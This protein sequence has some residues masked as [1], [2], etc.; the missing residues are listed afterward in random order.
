MAF[1]KVEEFLITLGGDD[2][3]VFTRLSIE[4]EM[5]DPAETPKLEING[6]HS[7]LDIG[8]D[9]ERYA[10]ILN[11]FHTVE[12]AL[13]LN[14]VQR[15]HYDDITQE[16]LPDNEEEKRKLTV[17]NVK[18]TKREPEEPLRRVRRS[19]IDGDLTRIWRI[20]IPLAFFREGRNE[21]LARRY[22]NA[23]QD[24]YYVL[25]GLFGEGKTKDVEGAMKASNDLRLC[26][27]SVLKVIRG[28]PDFESR[29][30]PLF[31][32]L[33]LNIDVD[34]LVDFIVKYRHRLHHFWVEKREW[35]GHP[36]NHDE[37]RD[38]ALV[39]MLLSMTILEIEESKAYGLWR[40]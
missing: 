28:N 24:F 25:E 13:T 38:P 39:L 18:F 6:D 26:S 3:G 19:F 34:G 37:F 12:S 9:P 31:V 8:G 36:F 11:L 21:F 1:K 33:R 30:A 7:R 20:E 27:D 14:G 5:T 17:N 35:Y 29:I 10:R 16:W 40:S 2:R 15:V 4:Y 22:I 23:F 32:S